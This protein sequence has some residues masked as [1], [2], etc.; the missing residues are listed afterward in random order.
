MNILFI[1]ACVRGKDSNTLKLCNTALEGLLKKNPDAVVTEVDLEKERPQ[2]LYPEDVIL[3][4]DYRHRK[5]FSH[6]IFDY[7]KQFAK[8]DFILIGAPYWDL[9]FPSVFKIYIER[10]CCVDITFAYSETGEPYSL[11]SAKKLLYVVTAGGPVA[12]G[13]NMGYDYVKRLSDM[14]FRV[15]DV[16]CYLLPELEMGGDIAAMVQKARGEVETLIQSWE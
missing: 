11:C 9:S 7:A 3:R 13:Y 15:P 6:P 8:A 2:S 14:F 16:R 10:I 12:E 4:D 5:D 1:N